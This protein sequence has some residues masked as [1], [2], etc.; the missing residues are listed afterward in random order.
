V[1]GGGA[2]FGIIIAYGFVPEGPELYVTALP[3][4]PSP[5]PKKMLTLFPP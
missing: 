4:V 5:F 2:E 1:K 3:K